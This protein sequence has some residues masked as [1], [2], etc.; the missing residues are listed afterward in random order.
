MRILAV[1]A[2]TALL[3]TGCKDNGG[4]VH[5]LSG[6][7][8]KDLRMMNEMMVKDHLLMEISNVHGF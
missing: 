7:M 3:V 1:F 8:G 2:L 4:Q 5:K 6:N